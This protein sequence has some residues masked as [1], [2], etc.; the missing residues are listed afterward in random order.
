MERN[1]EIIKYD[2]KSNN[3]LDSVPQEIFRK[4]LKGNEAIILSVAAVA[5]ALFCIYALGFTV[6]TPI[7]LRSIF[8]LG[9]SVLI[10]IAVP[11]S[12]KFAINHISFLD[13]LWIIIT[14][15]SFS[16]ILREGNN[17]LWR[18]GMLPTRYDI[19]F[20]FLLIL[21]TLEITRRCIGWTLPIIGI[22]FFIYAITGS[23][24][25]GYFGH[26]GYSFARV[27]GYIMGLDGVLGLPLGVA[28]TYVFL[29]LIFGSFLH[30]FGG[31][32]FFIDL[33]TSL[34]GHSRGGPA[35]IAVVASSF[36]GMISG[37]AV[38][39]TVGTGSFTIPLMKK[40]GYKSEFAGAVEA[41]ASTGGQIMPPIMGA[42]AFVI[43]DIVGIPY[44]SVAAVAIIPALLYYICVF[45]MVDLE[46][47]NLGLVGIPRNKLPNFKKTILNQGYLI[48]PILVLMYM[49]VV[50]RSSPIRAALISIFTMFLIGIIP[51]IIQK[52]FREIFILLKE[53]LKKASLDAM[54]V[55]AT[56]ACAGIVVGVIGLTGVG[57][58]LASL[59]ISLGEHNLFFAL[60]AG[61][62]VAI[63]LG[64]GV[65]TT[66]A[67]IVGAAVV[68]PALIR[69]DVLPIQSHLFTFYFSCIAVITPP[70][71]LAAYAAAAIAG[72]KPMN[73]GFKAV[74]LAIIAFVIPFLFI[75]NPLL[76]GLGD[77]KLVLYNFILYAIAVMVVAGMLKNRF[78]GVLK[79]IFLYLILIIGVILLIRPGIINDMTGLIIIITAAI[80]QR[81]KQKK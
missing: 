54:V 49:L 79:N 76:L 78:F 72:A 30:I 59:I 51:K 40:I 46:A 43:A 22:I 27:V 66:P 26:R 61:M 7:I 31:G 33:A 70:I 60:I 12:K 25:P 39:N 50:I 64:M 2:N 11:S 8:L 23:Y 3:V 62:I 80:Y 16:Y 17:L 52:K 48:L 44:I 69:L 10:F 35:K 45:T 65:P 13:L 1:E 56:C 71:A 55:T 14:I 20:G 63:I 6:V 9:S 68:A 57:L 29:F 34:F 81:S 4:N 37:S 18:I 75:Y 77:L 28:S 32:T 36:F 73:V 19:I 58:K 53:A 41:A 38:A 74:K 21:I 15:I 24:I 47:V 5:L 67:Y 42:G